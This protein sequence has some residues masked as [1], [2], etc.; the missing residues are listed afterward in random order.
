MKFQ[1]TDTPPMGTKFTLHALAINEVNGATVAK[2][3]LHI[4]LDKVLEQFRY[5]LFR[6][7]RVTRANG[8]ITATVESMEAAS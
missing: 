4:D 2:I 7:R 8:A 1:F 6:Q 3:A 5:K